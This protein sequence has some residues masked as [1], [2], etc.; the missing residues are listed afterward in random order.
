MTARLTDACLAVV[1]EEQPLPNAPK[2]GDSS[3]GPQSAS[4]VPSRE[5]D[6]GVYRKLSADGVPLVS[7]QWV[8]QCLIHHRLIDFRSNPIYLLKRR[9]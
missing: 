8:I 5:I 4:G 3:R 6:M 1:C 7:L 9:P 2:G